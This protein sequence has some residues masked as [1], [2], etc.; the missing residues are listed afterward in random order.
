MTGKSPYIWVLCSQVQP[1]TEGEYS[2]KDIASILAYKF[3][4]LI[5][6]L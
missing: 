4:V 5:P 6:K 3:L 2:E 1:T